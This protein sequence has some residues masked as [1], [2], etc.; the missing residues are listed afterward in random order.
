MA[1]I[2]SVLGPID[3]DKLGT[4]LMHEHTVAAGASPALTENY[5]KLFPDDFMDTIVIPG[6]TEAKKGGID[7][8]VD[9]TTLDPAC[10]PS[11]DSSMLLRC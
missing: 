11:G 7:T 9:C 2:N 10:H 6:L 5:P 3:T 4:S 8:I 1:I